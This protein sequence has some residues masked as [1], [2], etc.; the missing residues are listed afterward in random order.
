[1]KTLES[2]ILCVSN[3]YQRKY[4]LGPKFM[5]M[6]KQ[7]RDDLQAACVLFTAEVGGIF[8]LSFDDG[9]HLFIHTAAAEND[10]AYDDISAGL[11]VKQFQEE[12]RDLLLPVQ[13]YYTKVIK[14]K[15]GKA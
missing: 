7:V 15:T 3:A 1:M 9:E 10:A 14:G 12:N 11:K 8:T 4:Y 6:P 5:G 2:D 13:E